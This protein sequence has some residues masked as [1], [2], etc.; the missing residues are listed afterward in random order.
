MHSHA[1]AGRVATRPV[2]GLS[3]QGPRVEIPGTDQAGKPAGSLCPGARGAEHMRSVSPESRCSWEMA[4]DGSQVLGG[5]SVT[6]TPLRC[7]TVWHAP[8]RANGRSVF[9]TA[10][11]P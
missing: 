8:P 10:K 9:L 6:P 7:P 1:R 3:P 2:Q 11:R 5:V 4:G